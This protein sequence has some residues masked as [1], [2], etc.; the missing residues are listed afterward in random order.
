MLKAETGLR[1]LGK[2]LFTLVLS[3]HFPL[4]SEG[5]GHRGTSSLLAYPRTLLFYSISS[6]S[7]SS[8]LRP[9]P[10]QA[11]IQMYLFEVLRYKCA[12]ERGTM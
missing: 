11:P 4:L 7:S 10:Y 1:E 6:F 12:L 9:F 2:N 8:M 5:R 3:L